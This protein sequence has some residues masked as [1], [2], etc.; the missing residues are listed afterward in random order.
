MTR[1]EIEQKL[2][3]VLEKELQLPKGKITI[4]TDFYSS[5][6]IEF[7][8]IERIVRAVETAF[9]IDVDF[10]LEALAIKTV[11]QAADL[12]ESKLN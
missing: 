6:K 8:K 5:M 3:E 9:N 10:N 7:S 1:A 12:V 2:I 11:K 4:D